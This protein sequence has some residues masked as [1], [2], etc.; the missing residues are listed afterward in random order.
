M[1]QRWYTM[2]ILTATYSK[3][4]GAKQLAPGAMISRNMACTSCQKS[5]QNTFKQEL[6]S[7]WFRVH[8]ELPNCLSADPPEGNDGSIFPRNA[9]KALFLGLKNLLA[10]L[11]NFWNPIRLELQLPVEDRS[12][13]SCSCSFWRLEAM[14]F[15]RFGKVFIG[16][17]RWKAPSML[18]PA[19][20]IHVLIVLR[21]S[22]MSLWLFWWT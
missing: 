14:R 12:Y 19:K 3:S 15:G 18:H 7:R 20:A 5:K 9:A 22:F 13:H 17:A 6:Q 11:K 8:V 1:S 4:H 2:E 10:D 21:Y 16:K